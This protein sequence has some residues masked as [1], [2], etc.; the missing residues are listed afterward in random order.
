MRQRRAAVAAAAARHAVW[1]PGVLALCALLAAGCS[2]RWGAPWESR[3]GDG[4][5]T[6]TGPTYTVKAG[7]TLQVIGWQ[8]GIDHRRL[9]EWNRLKSPDRIHVGQ[10]LRLTPPDG[11]TSE[12]RSARAAGQT[13]SRATVDAPSEPA[14]VAAARS[15]AAPPAGA[16]SLRLQWPSAGRVVQT[17]AANDPGRKGIKIRGTLG[18]P[19]VAA[20]SGQVVYSGS[21]LVGYGPLIIVQHNNDYLTAYGHNR[22]LLVQ[23]GDHVTR[24][25]KI[26][27]MGLAA[28]EPMLH[29]EVRRDGEP[30]DPVALL[31]RR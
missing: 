1:R 26:A 11:G 2:A 17:Y 6:I 18:Q 29:F 12:A 22:K 3:E 27:E 28:G 8:S 16:A 31:P 23:Q 25:A 24:G 5:R 10:V 4:R 20:E 14:R 13:P 30:V 9:A 7:D 15:R 19:I 21:G